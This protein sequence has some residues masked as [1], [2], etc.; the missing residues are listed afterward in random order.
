MHHE[1]IRMWTRAS[2]ARKPAQM[3]RRRAQNFPPHART[4][5]RSPNDDHKQHRQSQ[6]PNNNIA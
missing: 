3:E 6:W 1:Y 4:K 5:K 2:A